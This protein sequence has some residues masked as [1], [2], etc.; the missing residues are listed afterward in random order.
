MGHEDL[1]K[2]VA[3]AKARDSKNPDGSDLVV[4]LENLPP[5]DELRRISTQVLERRVREAELLQA[6]PQKFWEEKMKS[7]GSLAISALIQ[8][9]KRKAKEAAQKGETSFCVQVG[10]ALDA[11]NSRFMA[12]VE[13]Y[14][15]QEQFYANFEDLRWV[16][17]S[18]CGSTLSVYGEQA[19]KYLQW[20]YTVEFLPGWIVLGKHSGRSTEFAMLKISW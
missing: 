14:S 20:V 10:H 13:E 5:V 3:Y 2:T 18:A 6:N 15:L 19:M 4:L 1:K 9:V 7:L 12:K 11:G 16:L 8:D 17:S